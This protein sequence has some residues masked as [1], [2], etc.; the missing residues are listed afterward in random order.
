MTDSVLKPQPIV[1]LFKDGNFQGSSKSFT[2]GRYEGSS[3]GIGNDALS[4]VRV[5]SALKV[6]LCEHGGFHG[7]R[8]TCVRDTPSLG[9][10][11]N[12]KVSSIIVEEAGAPKVI[13]YRDSEF[14]GWSVELDVGRHD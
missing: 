11:V 5:P 13:C 3:L 6:H 2:V 7:A 12:D 1:T 10:G 14:R 9:D 8:M 4:S